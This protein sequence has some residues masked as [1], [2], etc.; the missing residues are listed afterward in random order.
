MDEEQDGYRCCPKQIIIKSDSKSKFA[1]DIF[2]NIFMLYSFINTPY[3]IAFG[4]PN[5]EDSDLKAI[6]WMIDIIFL[7]DI[8]VTF[9]TDNYSKDGLSTVTNSYIAKRYL[10][11]FFLLDCLSC[12]P[13]LV[14]SEQYS[15]EYF[16]YWFKLFR[17]SQLGRTFDQIEEGLR[18]ALRNVKKNVIFNIVAF[19]RNNAFFFFAFHLIACFWI[20]IGRF[21]DD[22]GTLGWIASHHDASLPEKYRNTDIYT[23]ALYF[24][25]SNATTVGY[26]DYYA[27]TE[28]ERAFMAVAQFICICLF[29]Q[30]SSQTN[31]IKRQ[32]QVKQ[33]VEAKVKDIA[34]YR[35]S[36]DSIMK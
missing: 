14:T 33:I 31:V 36:I 15:G 8:I 10:T 9:I 5:E 19:A 30:I 7:V 12:V 34:A 4:L 32:P 23:S 2:T 24:V 1:W 6:E 21:P 22:R 27:S 20:T 13:G 25:I 28:G 11:S 17:F 3:N 18:G 16:I 26:G 29:S 35:Q